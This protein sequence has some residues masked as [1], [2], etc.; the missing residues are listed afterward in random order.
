MK[1]IDLTGK[2]FGRM[3]VV[4][5][6]KR[7]KHTRWNCLC[8]CGNRKEVLGC[9]LKSGKIISC[10]CA[11]IERISALN[12]THGESKTRLYSIWSGI[13]SRC[14]D[15][16]V[17]RYAR[18]G[19]RGITVCE[20][21]K[22]NYLSFKQWAM[23]NGYADNLSIDR[24]NNDGNYEPSNCRWADSQQQSNNTS[25]TIKIEYNDNIYS[26]KQIATLFNVNYKKFIYGFHKFNNDLIKAI[27]Y[28][29]KYKKRRN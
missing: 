12:K 26:A 24:I 19:S 29:K 9:H 16:N 3:Y 13:K 14:Y 22:N 2:K 17:S 21:W 27:N 28:A 5:I 8:D 11:S 18:Y 1:F 6:S 20:E 25:T 7:C 10:G 4:G 23:E 15:K